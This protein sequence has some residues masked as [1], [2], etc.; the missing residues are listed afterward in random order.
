MENF[1]VVWGKKK[2]NKSEQLLKDPPSTFL[3][4]AEFKQG[5]G[6]DLLQVDARQIFGN[7]WKQSSDTDLVAAI[8]F[9]EFWLYSIT[10]YLQRV[11]I[12]ELITVIHANCIVVDIPFTYL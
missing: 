11:Q 6:I 9:C 4:T 7:F 10:V 5:W 2:I 8:A 1:G 12:F 3:L